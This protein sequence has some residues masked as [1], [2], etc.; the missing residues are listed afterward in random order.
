MLGVILHIMS[1]RDEGESTDQSSS[2]D[3]ARSKSPPG[4]HTASWRWSAKSTSGQKTAALDLLKEMSD[5]FASFFG[6][7]DRHLGGFLGSLCDVFARVG[8]GVVR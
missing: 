5:L 7:V 8:G 4:R 2:A 3:R 1:L 6:V